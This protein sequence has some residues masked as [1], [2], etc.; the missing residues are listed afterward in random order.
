M[1]EARNYDAAVQIIKTAI[2]QSQY[3]AAR[4]VNEKQLTLYYGIGKYISLN[5]RK[6]FWGKGAIDAISDR[7]QRELPGLR[8]F[9]ARNLRN[10]R[11]FYE[12]WSMLDAAPIAAGQHNLELASAKS[13][14][15]SV[16]AVATA[17]LPDESFWQLQLPKSSDFPIAEFLKMGFTQHLVVLGKVKAHPERL[18]YIRR[19]AEQKFSV[20]DLEASIARDDYGHQGSLPNNFPKTLSAAGQA[21]RAINA[22]KDEY[23]LDFINVEELGARDGQDV[24]ERVVEN[25]IVHNVRNFILAFGKDF[26]FVRNQYHLDAFGEDQYID[27]LFFNRELNCLVAVEL[28]TGKFK[29]SYLGQLQGYLSVLDGFERK[30]HENPSIGLILCKDMN[31]SFVDYVIQ[32]YSK[33]MGVATYKTAEDMPEKLR[34]ALPDVEDLRRILDG[35]TKGAE[36]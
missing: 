7:L 25:A 18:F 9:S 23:L 34:K 15:S 30:P 26:T 35:D 28:K 24:D 8:G 20:E 4:S 21:L 14:D 33:P 36:P 13:P 32:D 22:F 10:M 3:D 1:N 5:S 6:G 11:T 19:C 16:L 2:L 27:L 12:E 31:K 17:K 29:T